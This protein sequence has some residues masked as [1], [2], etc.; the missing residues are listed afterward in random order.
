MSNNKQVIVSAG[1]SSTADQLI[2]ALLKQFGSPDDHTIQTTVEYSKEL[3]KI[4][5]PDGMTKKEAATDLMNQW[6][7]EEQMQ[8]FDINLEGWDWKD[9]L[10]A[11]RNVIEDKFGWLQGGTAGFWGP[12]PT[13]ISIITSYHNGNPQTESAFYGPVK[14][15][16]WE[17]A[18]GTIGVNRGGTVAISIAAKK[19]FSVAINTFFKEVQQYLKNNS[20]YRNKPIIVKWD[21][22]NE[23]LDLEITEIKSNPNIIL[24]DR[25][26]L[27]VDNFIIGQFDDHGKRT[28]LFT[29]KYGNGKSETAI[30]VAVEALKKGLSFFYLKDSKAFTKLLAFARKY[31]PCLVF[32]EDIDEIASGE[33]RDEEMN[34]ILNTLD[35]VETKGRDITVMFTTNHHARIAPA[36]RRPGRIDL[37]VDF[38]NPDNDSKRKIFE[39]YFRDLEG[40]ETVDYEIVSPE[41]GDVA[42][43]VVA[44]IA[45]RAV[46]Y[47]KLHG[48][49]INT[50]KVRAS[51]ASM[52]TQ[53]KFMDEGVE[54]V[55]KVREAVETMRE[56]NNYNTEF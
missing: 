21:A 46:K 27:V 20:I 24:N 30:N 1:Q 50:D 26:R 12:S 29:G 42:G 56:F 38:V 55:N 36:L 51:I 4:I 2:N 53:I 5:I 34:D 33:D 40:A 44:E 45:K 28:Y 49:Q 54:K 11:V 3:K 9:G 10:R 47:A 18:K 41:T 19:K 32:M 16:V 31:E 22:A 7:N 14:F 52:Q 15:A 13:E 39:T 17:D 35:G 25:E 37:I 48:N 6:N 23:R 8:D 43:A